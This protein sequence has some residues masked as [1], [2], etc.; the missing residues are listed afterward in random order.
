MKKLFIIIILLLVTVFVYPEQLSSEY[1][2]S[3]S[4]T[5]QDACIKGFVYGQSSILYI[6]YST[7]GKDASK[8]IYDMLACD[9]TIKEIVSGIT[10]F[11]TNP[12]YK[13]EPLFIAFLYVIGVIKRGEET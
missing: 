1:W 8:D 10:I 12:E 9:L 5:E 11:Y 6:I 4:A 2:N 13:E 3:L 7:G